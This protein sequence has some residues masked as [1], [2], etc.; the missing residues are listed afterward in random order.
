ML[1]RFF[2]TY[3]QT[4][5]KDYA[6][7]MANPYDKW[8]LMHQKQ[9]SVSPVCIAR[10]LFTY[11]V[12]GMFLI[13]HFTIYLSFQFYFNFFLGINTSIKPTLVRELPACLLIGLMDEGFNQA[14]WLSG[15]VSFVYSQDPFYAYA[16]SRKVDDIPQAY[17]LVC[18]FY[19]ST[20]FPF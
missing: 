8:A 11:L 17:H 15:C 7:C 16:R 5:S 6:T 14:A 13:F 2:L 10:S 19:F 18:L 9:L 12:N 20:Y 3:T 4:S 1:F